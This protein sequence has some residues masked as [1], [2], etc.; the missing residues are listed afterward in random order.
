MSREFEKATRRQMMRAG[1]AVVGGIVAVSS[2]SAED[3]IAQAQVQYQQTPKDGNKCSTCVNFQP[4]NA[5]K[6]VAGTINPNGWCIAYAPKEQ[7]KG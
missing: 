1:L 3:K 5:C 4:P 6:I 7:T 2:A